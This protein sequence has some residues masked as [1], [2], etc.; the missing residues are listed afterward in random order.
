MISF[1]IYNYFK[2][3]ITILSMYLAQSVKQEIA[4]GITYSYHAMWKAFRVSSICRIM[5]FVIAWLVAQ[6]MNNQL[7]VHG[8]K[9]HI[10]HTRR[11]T[12][13]K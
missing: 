8:W 12:Q 9:K 13:Q 5:L 3:L 11:N 4:M 1:K 2:V 7:M 10:L 6:A